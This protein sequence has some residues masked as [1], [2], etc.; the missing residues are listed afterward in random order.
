[1]NGPSSRGH[2]ESATSSPRREGGLTPKP[3]LPFHRKSVK[4]PPSQEGNPGKRRAVEAISSPSAPPS[5]QQKPPAWPTPSCHPGRS[6]TPDTYGLRVE[7]PVTGHLVYL[8][9]PLLEESIQA[10]C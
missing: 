5:N 6:L 10:D 7:I 9:P 8:P 4:V 3:F 1:M 2:T